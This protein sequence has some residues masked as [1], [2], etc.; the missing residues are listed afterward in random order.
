MF[1]ELVPN[2]KNKV[3]LWWKCLSGVGWSGKDHP[4]N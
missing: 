3:S 4:K 2:V 1:N